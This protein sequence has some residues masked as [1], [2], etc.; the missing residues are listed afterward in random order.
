MW[1]CGF[2]LV[3]PCLAL[4]YTRFIHCFIY[5]FAGWMEP[6]N[7]PLAT[8]AASRAAAKTVRSTQDKPI[9]EE[10]GTGYFQD[11]V[12]CLVDSLSWPADFA[13]STLVPWYR[14][15]RENVKQHVTRILYGDA[16]FSCKIRL[17]GINILVC[18]SLVFLFLEVINLAFLP[19]S[20]D[21][22][23]A[24]VGTYVQ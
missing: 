22:E 16:P 5:C 14:K 8:E 2:C 11:F 1:D 19:A 6:L 10:D 13:Q 18:C 4:S 20:V 21:H 7:D 9:E 3:L 24:V 12:D 17:T 23:V 15:Q